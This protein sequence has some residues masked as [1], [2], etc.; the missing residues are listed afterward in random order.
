MTTPDQPSYRAV[1]GERPCGDPAC[2]CVA[3][4][5]PATSAR[6]AYERGIFDAGVAEG[7]RQATETFAG[8]VDVLGYVSR[9]RRYVGVEPYPD[10]AARRVLG[11][12]DDAGLLVGPWEPTE[13]AASPLEP[14]IRVVPGMPSDTLLVASPRLDEQCRRRECEHV[15]E[16]VARFDA[17]Q[18][19]GDHG[20]R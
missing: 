4:Q 9:G 6:S 20:D 8:A 19:G 17:E 1:A 7:R 2:I 15:H 12:L 10:A 5:P 11:D 13:Q 3:P 16:V 14:L 18:A